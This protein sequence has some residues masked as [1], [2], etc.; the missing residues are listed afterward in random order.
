MDSYSPSRGVPSPLHVDVP[1]LLPTRTAQPLRDLVSV[2]S[3][4]SFVHVKGK[5]L[6]DWDPDGLIVWCGE[7]TEDPDDSKQGIER[8]HSE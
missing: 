5:T 6:D 3:V 4:S 2:S 1:Y 8:R 7:E